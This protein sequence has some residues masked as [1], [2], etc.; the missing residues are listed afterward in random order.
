MKW[1]ERKRG[2]KLEEVQEDGGRGRQ[3]R[4]QWLEWEEGDRGGKL[5][6][7]KD[8]GGGRGRQGR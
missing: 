1:E 6:E 7:V 2:G 8:D 4:E 5:G 3:G